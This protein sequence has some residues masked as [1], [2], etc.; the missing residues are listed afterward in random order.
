MFNMFDEVNDWSLAW[1]E[2]G[3]RAITF[4]LNSIHH[5]KRITNTVHDLMRTRK[6]VFVAENVKGQ[7]RVHA[8][9]LGRELLACLRIDTKEIRRQFPSHRF[10]PLF[11][12]FCRVTR[13]I[14]GKRLH[15]DNVD[16]FNHVV[17]S[18]KAWGRKPAVKRRLDNAQ[19][20]YLENATRVRRVLKALRTE[21]SKVLALRLDLGYMS[22][23]SPHVGVDGVGIPL[24]E[25]KLHRDSI[26][27]HLRKGPLR[28][29]LLGIIWRMEAGVEK[30]CHFH[31]AVFYCGQ[32][33]CRDITIAQALCKHWRDEVTKGRGYAHSCN[34]EKEKYHNRGIGMLDRGNDAGWAALQDTLLYVIKRDLIMRFRAPEGTRTFGVSGPYKLAKK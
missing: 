27:Q 4:Q 7:K 32:K 13:V 11:T 23:W 31:I 29:H 18:I 17:E 3:S 20:A 8:T 22:K 1:F 9:K 15:A 24:S 25:V 28:K 21:N 5:L 6:P 30:G 14:H 34:H 19:R 10:S 16:E 33:V 26:L 2:D 12:V